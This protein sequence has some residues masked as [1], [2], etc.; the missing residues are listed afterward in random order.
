MSDMA[1]LRRPT[2]T[3]WNESKSGDSANLPTHQAW[4]DEEWDCS[5]QYSEYQERH[6]K[7][8]EQRSEEAELYAQSGIEQ[9]SDTACPQ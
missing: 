7:S 1:I 8:K 5:N 4:R 6:G 9:F 3:L 2:A